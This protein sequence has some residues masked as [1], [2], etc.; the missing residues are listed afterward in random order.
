MTFFG[1]VGKMIR[2]TKLH[3]QVDFFAPSQANRDRS[4]RDC[5]FKTIS[6]DKA[7]LPPCCPILLTSKL[8]KGLS[9]RTVIK[10][11]LSKDCYQRTV[12]KGLL[13]KDCYQ[14]TVIKGLLSKDCYQRTVIKGLLS[15]DCYQRTVIKGLLSK[16]CYRLL[17][18]FPKS[19]NSLSL[20]QAGFK[21]GR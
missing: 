14:R 1:V 9:Q 13:S 10:G 2:A 20:V 17:T 21:S 15:K 3:S 19:N 16:D 6:K 8:F 12:I 7:S 4:K 18:F 11:L 5:C